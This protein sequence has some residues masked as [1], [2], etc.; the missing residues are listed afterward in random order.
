MQAVLFNA[1]LSPA[2]GLRPIMS[3]LL[4]GLVERCWPMAQIPAVLG[5][6][7][8]LIALGVL[9]LVELVG[10]W[11]PAVASAMSWLIVPAS[12]LVQ[13]ALPYLLQ[14]QHAQA[15]DGVT[16]A[17][18]MA[19]ADPS[20]MTSGDWWQVLLAGTVPM[21]MSVVVALTKSASTMLV[22]MVPDPF[23]NIIRSLGEG[24]M[25]LVMVVVA[26]VLL[27]IA[28]IL[29]VVMVI[30]A[31]LLVRRLFRLLRAARAEAAAE[32]ARAVAEGRR[33]P[34]AWAS[35]RD[36]YTGSDSRVAH[37]VFPEGGAGR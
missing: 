36:L 3:L 10:D 28:L 18:G 35:L 29:A 21:V 15:A 14:A 2:I 11:I 20:A 6:T 1:A 24:G 16:Q 17:A 33:A 13:Y 22:D 32:R 26:I 27:P 4:I 8:P 5:Q 37:E 23:T 9:A 7:G 25:A 31:A 30:A 19:L 12:G 34:S